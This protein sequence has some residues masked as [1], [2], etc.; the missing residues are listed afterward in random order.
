M[1][2]MCTLPFLSSPQYQLPSLHYRPKLTLGSSCNLCKFLSIAWWVCF[3]WVL[4]LWKSL[5]YLSFLRSAAI[6]I[7]LLLFFFFLSLL[8]THLFSWF[9]VWSFRCLGFIEDKFAH[10][11]FI[12]LIALGVPRSKGES[13]TLQNY[14][15]FGIL[16]K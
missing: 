7:F 10:L 8:F 2:W 16:I 3:F 6:G 1:M 4:D 13:S 12:L 5:L 9:M 14:L 11:F 15:Y